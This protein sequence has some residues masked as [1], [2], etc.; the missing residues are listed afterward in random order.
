MC[1]C[2][3]SIT[4]IVVVIDLHPADQLSHQL[5][6]SVRTQSSDLQ[7]A[8]VVHTL[9]VL[10]A[11]HHLTHIDQSIKQSAN[12]GRSPPLVRGNKYLYF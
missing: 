5:L 11:L 10:V 7:D 2:S 12:R 1:V 4:G 6:H 3:D 9:R 8:L